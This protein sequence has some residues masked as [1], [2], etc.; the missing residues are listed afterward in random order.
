MAADPP[1][2]TTTHLVGHCLREIEGALLELLA[3]VVG[4]TGSGTSTADDG[5][6]EEKH[7]DKIRRILQGLEIAQD[8]PV[9]REWLKLAGEPPKWAHR[10]SLAPPRPVDE[11][12]RDFWEKTQIVLHEVLARFETRFSGS[13]A[14]LDGLV[15]RLEPGKKDVAML[16][17]RIPNTA[18]TYR[19]F[20]DSM[21]DA[22]WLQ[23]LRRKGLF[24]QPPE[25]QPT[26]EGGVR[27]A[28]WPQS[29]FLARMAGQNPEIVR[30][31]ILEDIPT[32]ENVYVYEDIAKAACDMPPDLA[33][34][35]WP[36]A[37]EGLGSPYYSR[38]PQE[39]GDL[40]G[41]L[42]RGD[43]AEEALKLA[44]ELL[45]VESET[46][47]PERLYGG[48]TWPGTVEPRARFEP[49]D[50]Y[51]EILEACVVP[52]IEKIGVQAIAMLC[53]L[54]DE[55]V[56][57]ML[58][59]YDEADP[60]HDSLYVEMPII[61]EPERNFEGG[62]AHVLVSAVRDAC[63]WLAN[64]EPDTVPRM[65]QI[66]EEKDR[67]VFDRLV[68]HLLRRVYEATPE[69]VGEE[70]DDRL[71][72]KARNFSEGL[73]PEYALLARVRIAGM[74]EARREQL[75]RRIEEGPLPEWLELRRA[76]ILEDGRD[77]EKDLPRNV[78][79]WKLRRLVAF[80]KELPDEWK[81]RYEEL[82]E[83]VGP[84][85]E[86]P[87]LGSRIRARGAARY[88]K[89]ANELRTMEIGEIVEFL[90]SWRA[91]K[92]LG[93]IARQG[94]AN[95][96][97]AAVASD[98]RRFAAQ[99]TR[100][101]GLDPAFARAL[102]WGV[103]DALSSENPRERESI[104][105]G[106][107]W[108]PVLKLCHWSLNQTT[109]GV[110][111]GAI[112]VGRDSERWELE[113][114]L[115]RRTVAELLGVGLTLHGE[116]SIPFGLRN[117]VWK[118]LEA[119]TQDPDPTVV[120]DGTEATR[121]DANSTPYGLSINCVRGQA[122]H[123]IVRYALF[124]RR[125]LMLDSDG[126]EELPRYL[127]EMPEVRRVLEL[128][129]DPKL[130]PTRAVRSVY[131]Y[132]LPELLILAPVWTSEHMAQILPEDEGLEHLYSAAWE[133]YLTRRDPSAGSFEI[134]REH[135]VRAVEDLGSQGVEERM[136]PDPRKGLAEHLMAMLWTGEI[137]SDPPDDLVLRFFEE[138]SDELR[139]H[140]LG[141]LGRSLTY[142]DEE[143]HDDVLV[144]LKA[145]WELRLNAAEEGQLLPGPV[146]PSQELGAFGWWF[147]SGKFEDG[148]AMDQLM[149]ALDLG[150]KL[151]N[152]FPVL[153]RLANLA[154]EMPLPTVRC[155]E[156]VIER[157]G[158]GILGW[159]DDAK[160][161]LSAAVRSQDPTA[162]KA[163]NALISRLM[164]VGHVG[165]LKDLLPREGSSR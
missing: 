69:V 99:A 75:F 143:V 29:G 98:A 3:S 78:G 5:E 73:R 131:G 7:K 53:D 126:S 94:L 4:D 107:E 37:I 105:H 36:K 91:D 164:A 162:Q 40:V 14:L 68:F 96:L 110:E 11:D 85:E 77:P 157:A 30:S 46:V 56:G 82:V 145:L 142:S 9:A 156:K 38:L 35:M 67:E 81:A 16:L 23:P 154:P 49:V 70:I 27:V 21:V 116:G 95:E 134:L 63:E 58:S 150:A 87:P 118:A 151:R 52:L 133:T 66:L 79:R 135:Y 25:P 76:S 120:R 62:P 41:H 71:I 55:A 84:I 121:R 159:N 80:G 88:A 34:E 54:L 113:L 13:L 59:S 31:I 18:V 86:S 32:T 112:E 115:L 147:V 42:A 28:L 92:N 2:E 10:S 129:L 155:L 64:E 61:G 90:R 1:M 60:Y 57:I 153:R 12:F 47:V 24:K 114:D 50:L 144:R 102:L 74:Q 136:R 104:P 39:L 101:E 26:E 51:K 119:L 97:A 140:A 158:R 33:A 117:E 163:A 44:R 93:Y 100:F 132:W 111:S 103:H 8:E 89:T 127:S 125:H 146:P 108:T 160:Q 130:E 148:W 161:I 122:M 45:A 165:L 17:N 20:F 22:R 123:A 72:E 6:Q 137:S 65:V 19:Y 124:V 109:G 48:M 43:Q 83:E 15:A 139:G 141:F 138:A 152:E 149:R 128:H 106:S